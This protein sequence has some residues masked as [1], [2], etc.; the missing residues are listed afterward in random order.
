MPLTPIIKTAIAAS[1]RDYLPRIRDLTEGLSDEQVWTRPYPYGN[2]IGHLLLHLSGNLNA[3]I[4][5]G[6]AGSGYVRDREREFGETEI[7]PLVQVRLDLERAVTMVIATLEGQSDEDLALP[8]ASLGRTPMTSRLHVFLHC[9]A[10]L[11]HHIG[12]MIY[13]RKELLGEGV[14]G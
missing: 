4:G 12:Q 11:H 1:Y 8:F 13:L 6:M 10:H 7:L 3:Y 2:S 5:A 9:S 14:R